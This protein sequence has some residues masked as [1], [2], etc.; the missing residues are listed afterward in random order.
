MNWN[1]TEGTLKINERK[2]GQEE[3][4]EERPLLL[5]DDE[6]AEYLFLPRYLNWREGND[7]IN[8][9]IVIDRCIWLAQRCRQ[10]LKLTLKRVIFANNKINFLWFSLLRTIR[11]SHAYF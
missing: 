2:L 6:S 4:E 11:N 8:M 10:I 9:S 5:P 3:N 7:W 1:F